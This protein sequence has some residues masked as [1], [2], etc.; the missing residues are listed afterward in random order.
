MDLVA[1]D[2]NLKALCV[3]PTLLDAAA[4]QLLAR[5]QAALGPL[6]RPL[7]KAEEEKAAHYADTPPPFSFHPF[8]VGTQTEL[9]ASAGALLGTLTQL[10]ARRRNGGQDP[11]ARLLASVKRHARVVVGRAVMRHL[12]WQICSAF[13]DSPSAALKPARRYVHSS[14]RRRAVDVPVC[15]CAA[16]A[17]GGTPRPC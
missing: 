16:D 5:A 11:G 2:A 7:D 10:I 8:A 3:D 14:W 4:P 1:V 6:P 9:G 15:T 12:A 13:L 17:R